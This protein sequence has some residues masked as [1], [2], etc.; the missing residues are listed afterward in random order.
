MKCAGHTHGKAEMKFKPL[1]TVIAEA[2][3]KATKQGHDLSSEEVTALA[4]EV[5]LTVDVRMWIEHLRHVATRR[6]EGATGSKANNS[7]DKRN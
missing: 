3:K 6:K 5:L 1:S 7:K 2:H 4:K